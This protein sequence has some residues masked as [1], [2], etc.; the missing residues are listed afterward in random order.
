VA[1]KQKP[2]FC[3]NNILGPTGHK[4]KHFDTLEEARAWLAENGGGSIKK[5]NALVIRH[6][7]GSWLQGGVDFDPPLRTWGVVETVAPS[8][9]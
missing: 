4:A 1:H 6:S 3:Q 5:R 9:K 2:F 8:T 7:G